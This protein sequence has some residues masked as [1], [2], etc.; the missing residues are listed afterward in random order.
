MGSLSFDG[1]VDL[2]DETRVFDRGRF[3][4][5]L[6]FL[7]ERFPPQDFRK[8][9]EPGI[10]TGRVA[11]PLEERGYQMTGVD[12]SEEM[13]RLLRQ[14]LTQ[15]GR[16]LQIS[17]QKADVTR[18]PFPDGV[19]DMAIT[20]HL[21]YFIREWKTAVDEILRVV[22]DDGPVVLMHTGMGTELPF[23]NERYR[24]LCAEHGCPIKEVGVK[25]TMEVVDYVTGC[26][27]RVEWIRDRWQWTSCIQLDKALNYMRSRAYSFTTIVPDDRHAMIIERLESELKDRFG[28]LTTKI[29]IPNQIYLVVILR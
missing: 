13:L 29:E 3:D 10:G 25:S 23:L 18:L 9:F 4:A 12:I 2:Y 21:F 19:F 5:A 1:M 16:S 22:R 17:Y 27:Y 6:D 24:E 15:S 28:N 8:V 20:V 26:G 7:V 11:V 14:R